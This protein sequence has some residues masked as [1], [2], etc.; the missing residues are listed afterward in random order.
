MTTK[1]MMYD[2]PTYIARQGVSLGTNAA[3]SGGV[4][5]KFTVFANMQIMS[6]TA[7]NTVAGTSTYTQYN[8]TAICTAIAAQSFS[9]LRIFNTAAPG[10]TPALLTA[11]FGPF[12]NSV[13]NGTATGTQTNAIGVSCNVPLYAAPGTNAAGQL[14][15]GTSGGALQAGAPST[16]GGVWVN[17]GDQLYV[18]NGTDGSAVATF[19]LEANVLPLSN[20]TA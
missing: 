12:V 15:A 19:V 9:L 3:G 2:H 10:A 6:I 8:G 17:Q 13:Y 20:V 18:V 11:T 7:A 4:T 16:L 14:V 5:S 1:N